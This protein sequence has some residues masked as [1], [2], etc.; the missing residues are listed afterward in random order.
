LIGGRTTLNWWPTEREL[1]VGAD[2]APNKPPYAGVGPLGL[3]LW[4]G[5]LV[6][7]TLGFSGLPNRNTRE[8]L[9]L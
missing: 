3:A 6:V 5:F 1:L 9:K 8:Y 2:H 4:A 7:A